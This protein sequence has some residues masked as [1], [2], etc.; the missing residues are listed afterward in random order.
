M[1]PMKILTIGFYVV[2]ATSLLGCTAAM[3]ERRNAR[4]DAL[5]AD[6]A[7]RRGTKAH[8]DCLIKVHIAVTCYRPSTGEEP[9]FYEEAQR[10]RTELYAAVQERLRSQ[11]SN[12]SSGPKQ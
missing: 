6:Y 5:C 10:C 1:M 8:T 7:A 9:Y 11:R 12:T 2:L 4:L 3:E